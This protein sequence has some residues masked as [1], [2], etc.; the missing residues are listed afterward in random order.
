V[1]NRRGCQPSE[2]F[3]KIRMFLR[4]TEVIQFPAL[5]GVQSEQGCWLALAGTRRWSGSGTNL[6]P[7]DL[8]MAE[9]AESIKLKMRPLQCLQ[10]P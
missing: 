7:S 10:R 8:A 2:K 1:F 9:I 5:A 4:S 3:V 6:G